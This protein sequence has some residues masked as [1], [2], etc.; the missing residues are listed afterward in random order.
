MQDAQAVLRGHRERR[1]DRH[2]LLAVAV[3]E[4]AGDLALAVE[5]HRALLDAAHQ[6]HVAQEGDAIVERQVLRSGGAGSS[7]PPAARRSWPSGVSSPFVVADPE[8]IAAG[9]PAVP[10]P[11]AGISGRRA[12]LRRG[13]PTRRVGR[14]CWLYPQLRC[15]RRERALWRSRLRWRLRGRDAVARVR[16]GARRRRGAPARA[17]D[18][19]R[20]PARA[21][22]ALAA[23]GLLQPRRRRD[24]RA[25]GRALAAPAPPET[26]K[27]VADDRAGTVLLGALVPSAWPRSGSP[28]GPRS[29]PR[30]A[31]SSAGAA[32]RAL[33]RR[34][35]PVR[36]PGEPRPRRHLAPGT[37]TSAHLRPGRRPAPRAVSSSHR[38]APPG[39]T[40]RPDQRPNSAVAGP[41]NPAAGPLTPMNDERFVGASARRRSRPR[42]VAAARADR[43]SDAWPGGGAATLRAR[44]P[45]YLAAS[46]GRR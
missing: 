10:A 5:V 11:R 9:G 13:Y 27:V 16:A 29:R 3:V 41:D 39:V 28:T 1:A 35:A 30:S 23:G 34:A 31:T 45:C 43:A 4:R 36:V 32:A 24:R 44:R 21:V 38:P 12:R 40:R 2:G 26:P 19:G 6:E 17:A 14:A 42:R 22:A 33:R 8:G 25:A 7:T 18:R 37:S 46:L 20:G 15:R